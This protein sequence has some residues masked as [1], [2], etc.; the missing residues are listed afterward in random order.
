V[1]KIKKSRIF[2]L[3]TKYITKSRA[4][5]GVGKKN[6]GL[7]TK[8][9]IFFSTC[10]RFFFDG[11]RYELDNALGDFHHSRHSRTGRVDLKK[12]GLEKKIRRRVDRVAAIP[13]RY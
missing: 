1:A 5:Q 2:P 6:A 12:I 9:N 3:C 10:D 4:R 13:I 7:A 11:I 8:F